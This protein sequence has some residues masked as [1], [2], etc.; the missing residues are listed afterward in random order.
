M[1]GG[2]FFLSFFEVFIKIRLDLF[3]LSLNLKGKTSF[4]E[5]KPP[6][7]FIEVYASSRFKKRDES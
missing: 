2:I 7:I 3:R 5:K 6:M 4:C 1:T